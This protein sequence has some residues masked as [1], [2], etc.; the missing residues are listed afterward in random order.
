[1]TSQYV[2]PKTSA[3]T[4]GE[5]ASGSRPFCGCSLPAGYTIPNLSLGSD[6]ETTVRGCDVRRDEMA[7]LAEL[8]TRSPQ[9]LSLSLADLSKKLG[10]NA[11]LIDLVYE[12]WPAKYKA[13]MTSENGI[14]CDR[15][16]SLPD[17]SRIGARMPAILVTEDKKSAL[18]LQQIGFPAVAYKPRSDWDA[19]LPTV[20]SRVKMVYVVAD[21]DDD[22]MKGAAI[23]Q[24]VA[25]AIN[26][27]KT[28]Y[29]NIV[30]SP[31]GYND[32]GDLSKAQGLAAVR[33]WARSAFPGV[34]PVET[35]TE[36]L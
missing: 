27:S 36:D 25:D 12:T 15:L 34:P 8:Q 6:G 32:V 29:A 20:F 28:T 35:F 33:T 19:H 26:M 10:R 16:V 11:E 13:L 5:K 21:N 17:G 4:N 3:R 22:P 1:M 31:V 2:C 30:M 23:A 14:W 24:R 7:C 9:W 18:V